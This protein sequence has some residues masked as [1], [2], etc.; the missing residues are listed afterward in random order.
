MSNTHE[1][2]Q[3]ADEF[4][5]DWLA[6][7]SPRLA[8]FINRID[9]EHRPALL[10]V[11]VP[12]DVTYHRQRSLPIKPEDY[13]ELG[14]AAVA[15]AR[16]ELARMSSHA[17]LDET[18]QSDD[19][20][21]GNVAT[22]STGQRVR[23]FGEY[24]LLNEIARGGMGVVYK[25]RQVKLNR[26]VALKMI[27]SGN[28][29][30][31]DEIKRF[32]T[33]AEAA[34]NLYHPGI[35]P[36]YEIGEHEGQHYFSMGF[37]D[38]QSLQGKL[39]AGPLPATEAAQLCRKIA[40]AVAYAH[41]NGVI[42]RDLKPANV[43]LDPQGEPK[44]TDF[45]LAK[46]VEGDSGLTRTGAVMGTPSFMPPEQ[47]LGQTDKI[48]PTADVYSLGAILYCMMTGR[49]PFQAA[50]VVDT[51]KQVV[52]QQPV[53]PRSLNQ[54][55]PKDLDTICLKCL[56]KKPEARLQSAQQLSDELGRFLRGE[57]IQSR[58][59][60][61]TEHVV[62]W[63]ARNP[64][65]AGLAAAFLLAV[66]AGIGTSTYYGI[67]S[68]KSAKKA[69][70]QATAANV[71]KTLAEE[72][73]IIADEQRLLAE[74]K[75]AETL[76]AMSAVEKQRTIAEE[77]R[78]L[79][80]Q[81]TA[82]TLL[83]MSA[84]EKSK[85]EADVSRSDAIREAEI[86]KQQSR[87]TQ[88]VLLAAK[89]DEEKR[90]QQSVLLAREAV[91]LTENVAEA[92]S[93]GAVHALDRALSNI[94]GFPIRVHDS[95]VSSVQVSPSQTWMLT[96]SQFMFGYG[97][98][99]Q[100]LK[101]WSLKQPTID[102]PHLVVPLDAKVTGFCL[103]RAE[104]RLYVCCSE[105]GIAEWN[106]ETRQQTMIYP[107]ALPEV[108]FGF[109]ACDKYLISGN[110]VLDLSK[111]PLAATEPGVACDAFDITD[112]GQWLCGINVAERT[113]A[114]W[115]LSEQDITAAPKLRWILT[116]LPSEIKSLDAFSETGGGV[117]SVSVL[118]SRTTGDQS[119]DPRRTP[120][121][122]WQM[123]KRGGESFSV[124][125]QELSQSQ[126]SFQYA[127]N[128]HGTHIAATS[129]YAGAGEVFVWSDFTDEQSGELS[130]QPRTR[131]SQATTRSSI[132][133][134][135][136]VGSLGNGGNT[137]TIVIT[138]DAEGRITTEKG[139][140]EFGRET[141]T[142]AGHDNLIT[143]IASI[144]NSALVVSASLD[145]SVRIWNMMERLRE[146]FIFA[147][148]SIENS[149]SLKLKPGTFLH[150]ASMQHRSDLLI[151]PIRLSLDPLSQRFIVGEQRD[152]V[153]LF[154]L[155][156]THPWSQGIQISETSEYCLIFP[157]STKMAVV[158]SS[159]PIVI[160]LDDLSATGIQQN[161]FRSTKELNSIPGS[162]QEETYLHHAANSRLLDGGRYVLLDTRSPTIWSLDH[163]PS[164]PIKTFLSLP[165]ISPDEQYVLSQR[166]QG[167]LLLY[168]LNNDSSQIVG[169]GEML[170]HEA[171]CNES[172]WI[173][174]VQAENFY[175]DGP[176][177]NVWKFSESGVEAKPFLVRDISVDSDMELLIISAVGESHV[178]V[179][180]RKS[181]TA[182][183]ISSGDSFNLSN[184]GGHIKQSTD[185]KWL[186][187]SP[188]EGGQVI[189]DVANL[190]DPLYTLDVKPAY[191]SS[192]QTWFANVKML[193]ST[194]LYKRTPSG[195][196]KQKQQVS[197][198]IGI[199][200]F[201]PDNQWAAANVDNKLLL[202]FL[203][204]ESGVP[205]PR[206]FDLTDSNM[207]NSPPFFTPDS[208]WLVI[209]NATQSYVWPLNLD[210]MMKSA[211]TSAGRRLED[212]TGP[213]PISIE[214]R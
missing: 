30:G 212:S 159:P 150:H 109:Q 31:N 101:V 87:R 80:E 91:S 183:N 211:E 210:R 36:V 7:Q 41:S 102:K 169:D 188:S 145:G 194:S 25:A 20:K 44:V 69:E 64:V 76:L 54:Q 132:M 17:T 120:V 204:D 126:N 141:K 55:V 209:V 12:L 5:A 134:K 131:F 160:G 116:D 187:I 172:K 103:N 19:A 111:Q 99:D 63:C 98:G 108:S 163:E 38:G 137:S 182:T 100:L 67:E 73:T 29:A 128:K 18:L 124:I 42:H 181:V 2:D 97:A 123:T 136:A 175:T 127:W 57:P 142:L 166:E 27:L 74:Q 118:G 162:S 125:P 72:Q 6:D 129:T 167:G 135:S 155:D 68:G 113:V 33:E 178:I 157:N 61:R 202:W 48:G 151:L 11:L 4:E 180:T 198:G 176:Q 56:E 147:P 59:V 86:A 200:T 51:L 208:N 189:Y 88:M 21:S 199:V 107:Q 177:L 119:S 89:A 105:H 144:P 78:L 52:D 81:K 47:A 110:I 22:V 43:L 156:S 96:A 201:S 16:A 90:P 197:Q 13:T 15:I 75:A 191:W 34:A 140:G 154:D 70:E 26:V 83:A 24:E 190:K 165:T 49:P 186:M 9:V 1:I 79:A 184:G 28:I 214:M 37:V 115:K 114:A 206:Q 143:Q 138:G 164:Q 14:D 174:A 77:Q 3:I 192:D 148:D 133:M 149:P 185:G 170:S 193:H 94:R 173:V 153:W 161:I 58:P 35:V 205:E 207:S 112:D 158:G 10:A 46:K 171:I 65:V 195:F 45:G 121:S 203:A 60:S 50:S 179:A 71:A 23:Y 122:L 196:K 85:Q 66:T 62:R 168:D 130:I 139:G 39:A 84:A 104:D 8:E 92:F 82:E 213:M 93:T 32:Q 117:V 53:S 95:H 106:L 152:R 40:D 146:V